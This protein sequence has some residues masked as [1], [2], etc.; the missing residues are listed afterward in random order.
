M[1]GKEKKHGGRSWAAASFPLT[2][3]EA[4]LPWEHGKGRLPY[5]KA[6]H[7]AAAK[8]TYLLREGGVAEEALL[9]KH[10]VPLPRGRRGGDDICA[11][12]HRSLCCLSL[13]R[14]CWP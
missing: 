4:W 9:P 1:G 12:Y 5:R 8:A 6:A 2:A 11:L 13:S 10:R 14:G 3:S 7:T